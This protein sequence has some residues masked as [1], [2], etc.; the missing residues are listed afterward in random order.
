M[1]GKE[2][3]ASADR[4]ESVRG[5][6]EASRSDSLRFFRPV[7]GQTIPGAGV[8]LDLSG[9]EDRFAIMA[10]KKRTLTALSS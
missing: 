7:M 5:A 4:Q 10:E 8:G 1:Q 6:K 3:T 9:E 2:R